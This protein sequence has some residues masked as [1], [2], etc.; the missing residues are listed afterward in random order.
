MQGYTTFYKGCTLTITQGA[1]CIKLLPEKNS[2]Y[3]NRS[4]FF[5]YDKVNGKIMLTGNFRF[6]PIFLLRLKFYAIGPRFVEIVF[7][8][9]ECTTFA[10][11]TIIAPVINAN[12]K[13]N[14]NPNPNPNLNHY[15]TF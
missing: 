7:S 4:F 13:P 11:P 5:S 1:H 14:P 2:G 10:A 15:P 8:I 12:V 9:L 3:F 6:Y